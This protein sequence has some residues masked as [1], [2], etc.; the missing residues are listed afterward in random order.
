MSLTS[1]SANLHK[2][3]SS[4]A[5]IWEMR[6]EKTFVSDWKKIF[7]WK[8]VSPGLCML[9]FCDNGMLLNLPSR[10]AREKALKQALEKVCQKIY[11]AGEKSYFA[12]MNF[13]ILEMVDS[14]W[15]SSV[16]FEAEYHQWIVSLTWFS[17][18]IKQS[19]L[20]LSI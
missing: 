5:H 9:N 3:L 7:P 10:I 13:W 20:I 19:Y 11:Y 6:N 18:D 16:H 14:L 12:R 17:P 4:I 2:I 15:F 8:S 1:I